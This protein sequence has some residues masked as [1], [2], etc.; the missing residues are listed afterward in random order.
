MGNGVREF[1]EML[2][3]AAEPLGAWIVAHRRVLTKIGAVL[4]V[5]I[6]GP[7]LALYML[8]YALSPFAPTL[9]LRQD[10]YTL[11]RPVAFTFLDDQGD[12][13]GRRGA[14]VGERLKLDEM[15]P[16]LPAA[17]IAMED[18][19]FYTNMGID[20]WGILRALVA[21]IQARHWVAGGSTITQQTAKILFTNSAR[22]VSRKLTDMLDAVAL[23]KAL[24]KQQILELY[25][26]RL[27][28]GSGAYGVDGAAHVYFGKSARDLTLSQAAMLAT[29]TRAPSA[30]SPRRDLARAQQRADMV[31][32]AMADTGAI[33]QEQAD[34]AK[35][36]PAVI[37]DR[38]R[39]DARNYFLDTAANDAQAL[40]DGKYTGDLIVHTT[41]E[42]K[43]QDA[44]HADAVKVI[45]G[46]QGRRDRAHEAAVVVMKLDGAVSALLGG[47]DYDESTYNR[48]TQAHRQPGSAFKPFVYLAALEAGLTPWDERTDGPVDING[49][50]PTNYGGRDY[51][52]V[53]LADALAHSINRVTAEVAQEVGIPAVIEAAQRCGITS[54]LQPNASLALGTSDVTP[55]ELTSAYAAFASGGYK[56]AP[57]LVTE[58]DDDAGHVLYKRRTPEERRII[59]DHVDRDLTAMMYDVVTEGTGR[60]AALWNREAAG[61]TGTTQ[62]YHDA[63][64]VGFT[65]DYVTGVWVGNDEA[66]PMRGVTGG[67]LPAELWRMVMTTAE[68]GLP[69]RP[70]DRS[71]PGVPVDQMLTSGLPL[72]ADEESNG[73]VVNGQPQPQPQQP[74]SGEEHRSFW[75]WLFGSDDRRPPQNPPQPPGN[76]EQN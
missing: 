46:K 56:I 23:N 50:Q 3:R 34:E 58:I 48:A 40:V 10:L 5:A 66:T 15:P 24:S 64:F 25:L 11:N 37:T 39:Q 7:I 67:S 63:W 45:E 71:P 35:A 1:I 18:R 44:A 32:D 26:N 65:T 62:D 41:M 4:G 6:G 31:L 29:L 72:G 33:T 68:K 20:P 55:M 51:G 8:P 76:D 36:H 42:P 22:N 52:T 43:I 57:Y 47:V 59:A 38:T 69:A 75:D 61:K 53:T 54:P 49:W 2:S 16:Y 19:R 70:L 9:D 13:V 17:F 28:L 73:A 60:G 27:Y 14:I 12:V 30:F 74:Q 21:D